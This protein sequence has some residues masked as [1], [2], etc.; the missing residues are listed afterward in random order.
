MGKKLFS[1]ILISSFTLILAQCSSQIT[2]SED[3]VFPESEISYIST[4]EPFLKITCAY[5][6]NCH[7]GIGHKAGL[8]LDN[9]FDIIGANSGSFVRPFDPDGSFLIQVLEGTTVYCSDWWRF[10]IN[11]NHKAGMRKWIEEG[12][13]NN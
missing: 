8:V 3:I 9:H 7:N 6:S 4:V 12:A 10:E 13:L 11:D 2:S 1:L 5:T